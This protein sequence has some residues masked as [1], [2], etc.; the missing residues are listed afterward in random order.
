MTPPPLLRV[1]NVTRRFGGLVAV[2]AV[3]FEIP[4]GFVVGLIG[5]NGQGKSTMF[6]LII[7]A[8]GRW[9]GEIYFDERRVTGQPTHMRSPRG[10]ARTPLSASSLGST[11]SRTCCSACIPNSRMASC[12]RCWP[13]GRASG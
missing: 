2:D 4:R 3:S 8:S 1:E 11:C 13:D 6:D 10:I 12:V 7:P 9:V 5:P